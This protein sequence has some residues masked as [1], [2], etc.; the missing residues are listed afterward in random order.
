MQLLV[1]IE[2]CE[3]LTFADSKGNRA[4]IA[5]SIKSPM[6]P[7]KAWTTSSTI[8][9]ADCPPLELADVEE[10]TEILFYTA[11]FI[12]YVL[13]YFMPYKAFTIK[14]NPNSKTQYTIYSK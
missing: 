14:T 8:F 9:V 4:L 7:S 3:E 11:N 6:R 12:L 5:C 2:G 13:G 1:D 10:K